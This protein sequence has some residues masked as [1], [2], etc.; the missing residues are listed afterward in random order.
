ML[1]NAKLNVASYFIPFNTSITW[2]RAVPYLVREGDILPAC[3]AVL[4]WCKPW[5]LA[6]FAIDEFHDVDEGRAGDAQTCFLYRPL[7]PSE[8]ACP[9]SVA[10]ILPRAVALEWDFIYTVP[11]ESSF[12]VA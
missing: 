10:S 12:G 9:R 2:L 3:I 11:I 6:R 1:E 5:L 7:N 8:A 4:V